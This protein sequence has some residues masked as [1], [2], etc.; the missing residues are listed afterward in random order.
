MLKDVSISETHCYMPSTSMTLSLWWHLNFFTI[1]LDLI[2]RVSF[3]SIAVIFLKNNNLERL[4]IKNVI[5]NCLTV[6]GYSH[7]IMQPKMILWKPAAFW[8]NPY[9]SYLIIKS[10]LPQLGRSLCQQSFSNEKVIWTEMSTLFC[11][12]EV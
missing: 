8:E 2:S 6:M 12:L 1:R 7:L 4:C 9:G 11:L 3:I 5:S 10:R